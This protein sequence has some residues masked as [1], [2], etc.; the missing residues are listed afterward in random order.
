MGW[1][2]ETRH[3]VPG[4]QFDVTRFSSSLDPRDRGQ[5]DQIP[6]A[7]RCPPGLHSRMF[8]RSFALWLR[9]TLL[10]LLITWDNLDFQPPMGG[11][12][13]SPVK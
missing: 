4:L 10:I 8:M 7:H 5:S 6:L 1:H 3:R 2:A 11:S 9:S 13:H 12:M